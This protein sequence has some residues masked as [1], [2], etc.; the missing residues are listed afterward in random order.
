MISREGESQSSNHDTY[1]GLDGDHMSK[2]FTVRVICTVHG[3]SLI[4]VQCP[5]CEHADAGVHTTTRTTY[6]VTRGR[7]DSE[8][9]MGRLWK[10]ADALFGK[11]F[12]RPR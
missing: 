6:T 5:E 9:E 8:P 4:K 11:V 12:G 2:E 7:W 10:A 1:R 3:E